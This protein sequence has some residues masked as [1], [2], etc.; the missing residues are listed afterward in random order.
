[1]NSQVTTLASEKS[2]APS[3]RKLGGGRPAQLAALGEGAEDRP[4]QVAPDECGNDARHGIGNE[5]AEVEKT[6]GV[7]VAAIEN[8]SE[9]KREAQHNGHLNDAEEREVRDSVPE[10]QIGEGAKIVGKAGKLRAADKGVTK[11]THIKRVDQRR[12]DEGQEQSRKGRQEDIRNENGAEVPPPPHR[13]RGNKRRPIGRAGCD[14][15]A[16]SSVHRRCC[17]RRKRGWAT[18]GKPRP[19]R[20]R[21]SR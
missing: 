20:V 9:R 14:C 3:E 10:F 15:A 16:S 4:V 1:M 8:E 5:E 17:V 19:S 18:A 13:R 11:H 7:D 12:D 2:M 6:L 21:S